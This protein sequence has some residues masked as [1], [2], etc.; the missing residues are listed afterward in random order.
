MKLLALE[1]VSF[2]YPGGPMVLEGISARF[3][4]PEVVAIRSTAW[5]RSPV[6][7]VAFVFGFASAITDLLVSRAAW[8]CA[9]LYD[10]M[11]SGG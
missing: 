1:G 8:A 4:S 2:R 11:N 6:N 3:G 7:P 9:F 5:A 10:A